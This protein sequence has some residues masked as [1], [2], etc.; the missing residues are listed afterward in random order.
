MSG[1]SRRKGKEYELEVVAVLRAIF[2]VAKRGCAQ[3]RNA[4]IEEDHK[5]DVENTPYW[6]ECSH[7]RR[8]NVMAKLLQAAKATD[9]RMPI[10]VTR[11]NRG[12]SI[13]T[14]SLEH[15][16]TL[17]RDV[18]LLRMLDKDPSTQA[19]VAHARLDLSDATAQRAL[20][21]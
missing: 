17:L 12:P 2:P 19:A 8:I 4:R 3:A 20:V 10:A 13:A 15:L 21:R 5:A 11:R 9:G 6:I 18:E 16:V 1:L 7:G 14:L